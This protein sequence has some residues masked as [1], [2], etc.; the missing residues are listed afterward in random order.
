MSIPIVI[1]IS[2]PH[3][4]RPR[5]DMICLTGSSLDDCKKQIVELIRDE[6]MLLV[7]DFPDD[8]SEFANLVWY[9]KANMD[10]E[11][12]DYKIF[13]EGKWIVPWDNQEVY[14]WVLDALHTEDLKNPVPEEEQFVDSDE[15]PDASPLPEDHDEDD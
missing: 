12:F 3:K 9:S 11:V 8:Y 14:D 5:T 6:C 7:G 1:Q 4:F 10:N 15:E 2:R 13:H